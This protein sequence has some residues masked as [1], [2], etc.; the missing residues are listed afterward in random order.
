MSAERSPPKRSRASS[1]EVP[2]VSDEEWALVAPHLMLPTEQAGQRK[3]PLREVLKGL[4]LL[5]QAQ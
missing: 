4:P 2:E 3:H 1:F 5:A